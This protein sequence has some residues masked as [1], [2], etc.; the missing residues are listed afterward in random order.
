[1]RKLLLV[2]LLS[3]TT[4]SGCL[5]TQP[6]SYEDKGYSVA[7]QKLVSL[8]APQDYITDGKTP[9]EA[10]FEGQSS[11]D[12][13]SRHAGLATAVSTL[14]ITSTFM[15]TMA[16]SDVDARTSWKRN[17]ANPIVFYSNE[18]PLTRKALNEFAIPFMKSK[19]FIFDGNYYFTKDNDSYVFS[20]DTEPKIVNENGKIIGYQY[21]TLEKKSEYKNQ[22][23][24]LKDFYSYINGEHGFQM[25]VPASNGEPAYIIDKGQKHYFVAQK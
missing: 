17:L 8:G 6:K 20:M 18:K 5:S 10:K 25:Y 15:A 2:T 14:S 13:I 19:G 23:Q 24:L 16:S 21:V 7:K 1:M 11:I 12:A 22:T 3:L 9:L 4:L